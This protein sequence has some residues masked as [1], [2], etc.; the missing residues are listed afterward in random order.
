MITSEDGVN[1]LLSKLYIAFSHKD[2]KGL[3]GGKNKPPTLL[4]FSHHTLRSSADAF[5]LSPNCQPNGVIS[6]GEIGKRLVEKG[7]EQGICIQI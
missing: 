6:R 4:D 2:A 3:A 7:F 5:R 1:E